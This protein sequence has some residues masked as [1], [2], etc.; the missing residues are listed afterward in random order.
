[1]SGINELYPH[2]CSYRGKKIDTIRF[3]IK[4]KSIARYKMFECKLKVEDKCSRRD[5]YHGQPICI[6]ME[7]EK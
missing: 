2:L 1:M 6:V 3:E 4:E 7:N 5:L